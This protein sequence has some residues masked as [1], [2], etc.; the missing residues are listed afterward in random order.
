MMTTTTT[1]PRTPK[2]RALMGAAAE[3]FPCVLRLITVLI[4]SFHGL[5]FEHESE[6]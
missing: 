6:A 4:S 3:L 1:R 2:W 5:R